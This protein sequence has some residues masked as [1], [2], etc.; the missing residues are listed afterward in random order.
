MKYAISI[1]LSIGGAAALYFYDGR[2]LHWMYPLITAC[3]LSSPFTRL[4]EFLRKEPMWYLGHKG[5]LRIPATIPP[6]RKVF[7]IVNLIFH[8][9]VLPILFYA[10]T[11]IEPSSEPSDVEQNR[12]EI[13]DMYDEMH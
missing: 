6:D 10:Y 12:E 5:I 3:I 11:S 2:E 9:A 4:A 7:R 1:P 8:L 13:E